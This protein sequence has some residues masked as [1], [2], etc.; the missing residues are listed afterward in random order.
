MLGKYFY[1]LQCDYWREYPYAY[2]LLNPYGKTIQIVGADCGSSA[3]Y[4]LLRGAKYIIQYEKEQHLRD[5]WKEVCEKFSICQ[6]AE[7]KPEWNGQYDDVNIF[8]MDCE[9]CEENLRTDELKKY[10]QYCIAVHDWTKNRVELLRK[11]QGL[12]FT[13]VTDDGKEI[14]LC[15]LR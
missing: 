13:Y 11:L 12:T 5:K 8:I 6:K 15:K 9:G 10:E 14:V 3:L 7:M 2:G 1:D 4:F